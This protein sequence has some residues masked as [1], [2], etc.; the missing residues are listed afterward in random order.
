MSKPSAKPAS[1]DQAA[2]NY[3]WFDIKNY[4]CAANLTADE[5][6]TQIITR[7]HLEAMLDGKRFEQFDNAF[8]EIKLARPL[9]VILDSTDSSRKYTNT[10]PSDKAIYPLKVGV[11]KAIAEMS[12][13]FGFRDSDSIDGQLQAV[14]PNENSDKAYLYVHANAPKAKLMAQFEEWI[15]EV[16]KIHPPKFKRKA[17]TGI[18]IDEIDSWAK[19][20][21]EAE[22]VNFLTASLSPKDIPTYH[23]ILPYQDLYLW[24]KRY[25]K[26]MPTFGELVDLLVAN[27]GE[28]S[29]V[30]VIKRKAKQAFTLDTYNGLKLTAKAEAKKANSK[31]SSSKKTSAKK[32]ASK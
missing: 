11:A 16:Q 20:R 12:V 22:S 5:W 17:F 27:S 21:E 1:S 14:R 30:Q 3:D 15:D 13:E 10:F 9:G 4:H 6:A 24:H 23:P 32:A 25:G 28:I 2:L 26:K 18:K 7:V 8:R 19:N 31:L 29:T